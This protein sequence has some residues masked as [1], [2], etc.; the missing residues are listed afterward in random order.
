MV[1]LVRISLRTFWPLVTP[2]TIALCALFAAQTSANL[3]EE[4]VLAESTQATPTRVVE[5]VHEATPARARSKSGADILERNMF[6]TDC[7]AVAVAESKAATS[8]RTQLPL[9]L[10]ATNIATRAEDSFASILNT[11]DQ[12]Q[13]GYRVGQEIPD[14]GI[15]VSIGRDSLTFHNAVTDRN[16]EVVFDGANATVIAPSRAASASAGSSSLAEEY[17]RVI[18]ST[19]YEVDRKLIEK[20][21]G[22]PMLGGARARPVV[23]DGKMDGVRLYA[24]R[25]TGL[26]HAM[27]LRNGDTLLAANGVKLKSYEAGLELM[28][29]LKGRDHW[30][31]DIQR[32][33]KPITLTVDLQ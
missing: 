9:R 4:E 10:I 27:G 11:S 2:T 31:V 14:A 32:R 21:Q 12:R 28:G 24:V 8:K 30:S 22:N 5:L 33:G 23:K 20:L 7:S 15:V 16:E 1:L 29:Q 6:C 19:H 26:A 17:V 25:S 3:L 18:D 13:G